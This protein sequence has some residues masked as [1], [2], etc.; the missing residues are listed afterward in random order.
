MQASYKFNFKP[1]TLLVMSVL[2]F[3]ITINAAETLTTE[4]I[5]I[6]S[7]TPLPSLGLPIEDVPS[8]VQTVKGIEIQN[9]K[10]ASIADYISNNMLGVNANDTQN[11]PFQPDINFHGFTA[12]PLAGA[13]QG[14][15]VYMDGVRVNQPFGDT[16][17]WDLIPQNA[18]S[19][20]AL[21]P[22]SNP[23]F[24]LN[25]LGG[26]LSMQTKSGETNPG[27]AVQAGFGSWG[28]KTGEAEIGGKLD[29][30][31]H[32]FFSGN[33]F[34]EDGWRKNSQSDVRQL[35]G[36]MGWKGDHD[37][38][39]ISLAGAD[40]EL[41]GNGY[42]P[43]TFLRN[44]GQDSLYTQ[45]DITRNKQT[46]FTGQYNHW[47][48]DNLVFNS[49]AY[50]RVTRTNSYNADANDD[51]DGVTNTNQGLITRGKSHQDNYGLTGQFSYT[52]DKHNLVVGAGYD[53][54][55]I[56]Y[57]QNSQEFT[58]FSPSRGLAGTFDTLENDVD[59]NGR[60][61]TWSLFAT[62]TY[63]LS[64]QIALTAS[65]RYNTTK[66]DNQDQLI[67]SGPGS[68]TGSQTFNRFNPAIGL[69]YSPIQSINL[70]GGY[71]EGNR[72]PSAIEIGCSD[73]AVPCKLPNS[74]AG[75]PPTL[76]QV[77]AKTWEA[78]VRGKLNAD[79]KWTVGVYRTQNYDDIQFIA[80]TGG[81]AGYFDNVGRTK[82]VGM[83]FGVDGKVGALRWLAGYS[84]I[85]ATYESDFTVVS[86]ANSSADGSGNIQVSKGD[87]LPGIPQ[88]QIKLRLEYS[89]LP[90]WVVGSNVV[91]Y[92]DQFMRGNE[93]NADPAGKVGGYTV[94]NL[95]TR[96]NFSQSGWQVFAKAINIFDREYY[97]GGLIAES[98]FTASGVFDPNNADS[99]TRF[100]APGA[101]R[102]AWLGVR[103]EFGVANK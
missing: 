76:K 39:T 54:S 93:N 94:V 91:S 43:Q 29:N 49:V 74:M 44:F 26:A 98:Q 83:D 45:P 3:P 88:H 81:G 4:Q 13:A 75:D 11:N 42:A 46:A 66:V 22:G 28:R 16:V 53:R 19:S 73:P 82:R 60:S 47:F 40:N 51:F 86:E 59:L 102:A 56:K 55:K 58:V 87:H 62:N 64:N 37:D 101:P 50:Y 92:S 69:T 10:G 95:D 8:N 14:L 103:Y 15:S 5:N 48:N 100:L 31:A 67:A 84:Y 63:K 97:N 85:R 6:I 80:V 52:A 9:Q 57:T 20:I 41:Y 35:F 7:T 17:N 24:G 68:L 2:Y 34:T 71:N 77:V 38:F 90:N 70:Y 23:L 96:Y 99:N 36:K 25:T 21:M 27:A 1:I 65:G 78:G 30:G 61:H 89:V 18:I 12:T 32:Y 79:T 33:Y 72:A